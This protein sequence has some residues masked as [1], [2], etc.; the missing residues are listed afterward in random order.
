MT[1]KLDYR[2]QLRHVM[3]ARGMFATTDLIEPLAQ[4]GID[5]S[6]SLGLPTGRRASRAVEPESADGAAGHSRHHDGGAHRTRRRR[7]TR[8]LGR[9]FRWSGGRGR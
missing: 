9:S 7:E 6:S 8:V 3:A 4:R 5:L 1:R 2:W